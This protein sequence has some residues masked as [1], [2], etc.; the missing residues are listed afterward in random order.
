[1]HDKG[2]GLSQVQLGKRCTVGDQA[3]VYHVAC[4][5][6]QTSNVVITDNLYIY[7]ILAYILLDFGTANSFITSSFVSHVGLK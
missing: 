6:A 1:M 7:G 2:E 5:D 4:Q 3:K